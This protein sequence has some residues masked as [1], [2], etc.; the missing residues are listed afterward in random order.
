MNEATPFF[1]VEVGGSS[2]AAPCLLT[3]DG[4]W[5]VFGEASLI[6][7]MCDNAAPVSSDIAV[8]DALP[9]WF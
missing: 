9:S 3:V 5:V 7:L 2:R 1:L 8:E 4:V 6:W